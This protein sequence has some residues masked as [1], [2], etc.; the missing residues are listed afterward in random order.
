MQ[1]SL[2]QSQDRAAAAVPLVQQPLSNIVECFEPTSSLLSAAPKKVW[3][4][5]HVGAFFDNS[6]N[7]KDSLIRYLMLE[8]RC[9]RWWPQSIHYFDDTVQQFFDRC[10]QKGNMEKIADRILDF[11]I[12][13]IHE[14]EAQVYAFPK[15]ETSGDRGPFIP[16]IFQKFNDVEVVL[17]LDDEDALDKTD[18]VKNE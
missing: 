15:E 14:I 2:R 17:C 8:Q 10:V 9:R 7:K 3:R 1:E 18:A 11:I 12:E 13:E 16:S 6:V 5:N 4:D